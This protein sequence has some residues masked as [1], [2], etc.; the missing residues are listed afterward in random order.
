MPPQ[1]GLGNI[2]EEGAENKTFEQ[3]GEQWNVVSGRSGAR[4]LRNRL[5]LWLPGLELHV[6]KSVKLPA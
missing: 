3:G 1:P 4:A 2:A 6:I 5:E